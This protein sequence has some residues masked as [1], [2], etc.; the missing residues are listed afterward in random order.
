LSNIAFLEVLRDNP[1][2][3]IEL[4]R[5]A[6]EILREEG[7]AWQ[8]G[9]YLGGLAMITRMAGNIEAARGHL[10]EAIEIHAQDRDNLSISMSLTSLA[11]IANDEGH[12]ERAA[13]LIGAAARMRDELGGGVPPEFAD[14]WGDPDKDARRALG[15]EAYRR[16]R[17][18]AYAMT[19]EEAVAYALEDGAPQTAARSIREKAD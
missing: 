10:R 2:G 14:R 17:A 16:A 5:T 11:L 8:V 6:I 12:H 3:A 4:R 9:Q 7:A 18:E 1:A 19:D 13:R 15:E